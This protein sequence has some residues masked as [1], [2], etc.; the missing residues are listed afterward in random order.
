MADLLAAHYA[1]VHPPTELQMQYENSI[2]VHFPWLGWLAIP[3]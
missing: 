3:H 2:G 1:I